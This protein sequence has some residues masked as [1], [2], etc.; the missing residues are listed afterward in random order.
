MQMLATDSHRA[1]TYKVPS[2]IK[3]IALGA[4]C[5]WWLS[6]LNFMYYIIHRYPITGIWISAFPHLDTD[7]YNRIC[8]QIHLIGGVIIQLLGPFQLVPALRTWG[9][10]KWFGRIYLICMYGA[11]VGGEMFMLVN[12]TIGGINMTLSFAIYGILFFICGSMAFYYAQRK[13]YQTHM[14]WALLTFSL[15]IAPWIYR[16]MYFISYIFGYSVYSTPQDFTRPLD[17]AFT[18]LFYIPNLLITSIIIFAL[19]KRLVKLKHCP[20]FNTTSYICM[21]YFTS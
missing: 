7:L 19:H 5:L 3:Y 18:W 16:L 12:P 21:G 17:V 15:G 20:N 6:G 8:M 2:A 13:Q 1:E 11:V 9:I 14:Y 4:L 10:H